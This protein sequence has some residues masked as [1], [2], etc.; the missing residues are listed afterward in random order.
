MPCKETTRNRRDDS[1]VYVPAARHPGTIRQVPQYFRAENE[2]FFVCSLQPYRT[3]HTP[4][5][6]KE[7]STCSDRLATSTLLD[8]FTVSAETLMN[9]PPPPADDNGDAA[10]R[11]LPGDARGYT[12]SRKPDRQQ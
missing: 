6:A 8:L 5:S 7:T 11:D 1:P 2:K 12:C 10:P 3:H 4:T 9:T